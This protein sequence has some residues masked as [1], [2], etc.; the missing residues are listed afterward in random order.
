MSDNKLF[1]IGNTIKTSVCWIAGCS[2]IKFA[3]DKTG[4]LA[5]L[6]AILVLPKFNFGISEKINKN[7]EENEDGNEHNA[8]EDDILGDPEVSE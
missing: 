6:L 4:S 8:E 1:I 5:P 7:K 2:A 3:I